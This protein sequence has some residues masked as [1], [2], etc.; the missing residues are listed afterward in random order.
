M[1]REI[2]RV[3]FEHLASRI[4]LHVSSC[5]EGERPK[6]IVVSGGVA[7][8]KYLR[9]VLREILDVRG[10]HDVELNFP[11]VELCTDNALMIAWAGYEMAMAGYSSALDVGPIR[12]WSMDSTAT[13]GGILGADG[14]T[15]AAT[16]LN[17]LGLGVWSER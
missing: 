17:A 1:A 2:Q 14:W 11:P 4:L 10:F 6:T 3:A 12:K 7:S 9:R 16:D 15:R 5:P 13:D 8:N